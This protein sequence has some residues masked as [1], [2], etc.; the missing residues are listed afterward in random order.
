MGDLTSAEFAALH[1]ELR[2]VARDVLSKSSTP[3]TPATPDWSV[4]A[5]SGWLGLEAPASCDGAEATFAETAVV[6]TEFGRAA[7]TSAFGEV[8][9]AVA[10]LNLAPPGAARDE[11]LRATVAG[12]AKPVVALA[13]ED[14]G[15]SPG[16]A[17]RLD[18]VLH[19]EASFVLGAA[20]ADRLLI[21]ALSGAEPVL[22]VVDPAALRITEAPVVDATR[23][24]AHV[25]A[26]GAQPEE[27]WPFDALP[28]VR[29][30]AAT[31]IACDS[32][33]VAE[34]MLDATV[35]HVRVREQFGRKIGSFQAVQHAC[36]D[37]LVELTIARKLV[38]A[39]VD[40]VAAGAPGT[41]VAMAKSYATEMAVAVAGKA[42]QLHGGMGYTWESGVHVYLK[43]AALNRSLSGSPADH[44]RTLAAG[45]ASSL[46]GQ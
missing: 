18:S 19:G 16:S 11:L 45:Y 34:A 30:R 20:Q 22:A 9:L 23:S 10:A 38:S 41:H 37:M 40:A 3:D 39:A 26:E 27:V 29:A 15:E 7:A 12:S 17:F 28:L 1:D 43:R 25:E 31:G 8:A 21:P 33:G 2:A 42:M 14:A 46:T 13:G 36:A 44:R 24:P 4:L 6:L 5:E 32:V 35:A